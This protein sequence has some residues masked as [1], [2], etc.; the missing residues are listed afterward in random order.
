MMENSTNNCKKNLLIISKSFEISF[1]QDGYSC[2]VQTNI[3]LWKEG[4]QGN[5]KAV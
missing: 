3:M 5:A 4:K 2:Y 1:G